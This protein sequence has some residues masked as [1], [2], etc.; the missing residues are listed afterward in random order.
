M[1][2]ASPKVQYRNQSIGQSPKK[3]AK[4]RH[5]HLVPPSR[6]APTPVLTISFEVSTDHAPA[7]KSAV[8]EISNIIGSRLA[9]SHSF[10]KEAALTDAAIGVGALRA[11]VNRVVRRGDSRYAA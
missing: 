2:S 11:A 3:N 10:A 9:L 7:L 8:D 5:L 1:Q 6:P 4:K